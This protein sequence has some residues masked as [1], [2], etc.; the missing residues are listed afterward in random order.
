MP[1]YTKVSIEEMYTEELKAF[2]DAV[3]GTFLLARDRLLD[4]GVD[5]LFEQTQRGAQCRAAPRREVRLLKSGQ[6][7]ITTPAWPTA[8]WTS[9]GPTARSPC[10]T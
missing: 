1:G 8:P 2:L 4:L 6:K 10:A 9:P 5:A 7:N 3:Q